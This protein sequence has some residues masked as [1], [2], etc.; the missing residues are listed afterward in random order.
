MTLPQIAP[1]VQ[2]SNP[3]TQFWGRVDGSRAYIRIQASRL[4]WS[5]VGQEWII[6]MAP[7][8][9]ITAVVT[10]HRPLSSSLIVTTT[11]GTVEFDVESGVAEQARTLL[12]RLM[13]ESAEQPPSHGTSGVDELINLK[14]KFD[15]SVVNDFAFDH[16]WARVLEA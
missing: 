6:T 7:T 15:T 2:R 4:E 8:T 16:E 12:V 13:G 11:V 5:R 9:S 3:L 1:T 14:W 10:Q